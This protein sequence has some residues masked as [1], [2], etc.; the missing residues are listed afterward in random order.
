MQVLLV[1]IL[2]LIG[3]MLTSALFAVVLPTSVMESIHTALQLGTLPRAPLTDYLAR[4]TAALYAIHGGV[5]LLASTDVRRFEPL[6]RYCGAVGCCFGASM[7][8]IDAHAGMPLYWTLCE[9]PPTVAGNAALLW[10]NA[11]ARR[12]ATLSSQGD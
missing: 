11:Q 9:G 8:V 12:S 5:L 4:S 6:I 10:V 1:W 7:I 2:R 3:V